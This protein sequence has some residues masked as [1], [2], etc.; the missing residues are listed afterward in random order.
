MYYVSERIDTLKKNLNTLRVNRKLDHSIV[1]SGIGIHID[2]ISPK[3]PLENIL[4][5]ADFFGVKV[6]DLLYGY[7]EPRY[8][9]IK[10]STD[11]DDRVFFV[12]VNKVDEFLDKL[13]W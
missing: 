2:F 6:D 1:H 10:V 4:K 7:F 11:D 9:E 13:G 3:T 8:K 12:P 5:A